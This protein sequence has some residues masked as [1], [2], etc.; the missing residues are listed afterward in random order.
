MNTTSIHTGAFKSVP[1]L[2]YHP[3]VLI[4]FFLFKAAFA[5]EKITGTEMAASKDARLE[6]PYINSELSPN[7]TGVLGKEVRLACHVKY[8]Q[9]KTVRTSK[10]LQQTIKKNHIGLL[11]SRDREELAQNG[12]KLSDQKDMKN[13]QKV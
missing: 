7:V 8:L 1:L 6:R 4:F 12:A 5:T 9:N 3:V 10:K 2:N 13:C 11:L